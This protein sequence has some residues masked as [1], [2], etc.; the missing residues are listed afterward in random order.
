MKDNWL[1]SILGNRIQLVPYTSRHVLKYHEWMKSEEI[2][3]LTASEPLSLEEEYE[4][5]LS[6]HEDP[7]KYLIEQM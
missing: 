1:I 3:K 6:W 4:M 7:N 2:L 5:Q